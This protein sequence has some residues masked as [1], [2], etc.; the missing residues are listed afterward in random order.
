MED[1]FLVVGLGSMGKRRIRNL[2]SLGYKSIC[3]FDIRIDRINESKKLFQIDVF[4]SFSKAIRNQKFT[5]LIISVP[6]EQH[7][8]YIEEAIKLNIPCF[9]EAGLFNKNYQSYID[10]NKQKL[11]YP[12][13]TLFFH[14]A[15]I[16]IHRVIK[17]STLGK[18][19]NVL[20]HSG[21]YLPDWHSYEKV[22][23][24]YV[25]KKETGGAREIVPFELTWM[26]KVF[27]IPKSIA[28]KLKKTINIEGAEEIDDT[29]NMILDQGE[30]MMNISIDV[31]SRHAT[32]RLTINGSKGQLYW[33]WNDDH[34]SI[35]D[36]QF[37]KWDKIP[38]EVSKANQNY[39]SNITEMMYE[40]EIKSFVD[41]FKNI[42]E[43]PNCIDFDNKILEILYAAERSS[44]MNINQN[45]IF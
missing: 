38:Y 13:C 35:Y 10:K 25:S 11:I 17:K 28:C 43:Y 5:A 44:K 6:P 24:Y 26:T 14:P 45:I 7:D 42:G 12:S 18:L 2:F 39:N 3:G 1:N 41:G 34:I 9:V 29:Y 8:I 32:R 37:C 19:S 30:F 15:I 20:Y 22:E 36:P 27:G 40:K 16:E 4:D 23:E 21:Q 33:D 31:V